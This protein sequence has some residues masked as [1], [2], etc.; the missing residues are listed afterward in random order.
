MNNPFYVSSYFSPEYF[1]DREKEAAKLKGAI[2]NGRNVVLLSLRRMGKT[3]LIKH[4]FHKLKKEGDVHVIY[5]DI[6]N[7]KST[8]EFSNLL[9]NSVFEDL[10]SKSKR[11]YDNLMKFFTRFSPVLTYD[12]VT[13]VPSISLTLHNEQRTEAS[14]AGI[15]EY[16]EKQNKPVVIAIDEFQQIVNFENKGFEAFLRSHIQHLNN[17]RFI[18]SGSQQHI[19]TDM[20]SSY[21]RPFYQSGD[22][23]KLERIPKD[24][25]A[26]F[27]VQKF[28]ETRK[29]IQ[30]EDVL[31]VMEWLDVYTFYVQ[32]F[33]NKLW[34]IGGKTI[35]NKDIEKTKQYVLD[36]HDFIYS[37]M[38]NILSKAQYQ[39]VV[40][41]AL[42]DGVE[43]PTSKD[44]IKRY[45]LGTTS[46]VS[47]ALK[48]LEE[49][50]L[51]YKENG[52][53]EIYD[54]FFAK[55]IK[56]KHKNQIF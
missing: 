28:K 14:V 5:M 39:I 2:E 49:K 54:V 18:F 50:E 45:D 53:Y 31:E 32:S 12:S 8:Q 4:L 36:E 41:I 38:S 44:F 16:L 48:S 10:S 24:V 33:F 25:Y 34:F 35:T 17:V 56:E 55:W 22:Y 52:R 30:T 29:I 23:L 40:A 13:G 27:I 42:N 21:S 3:G 46:T 15:F 43:K 37:N 9:A 26:G 11:I 20:F 51:I 6:V 7:A 1:C 47:S 19:L